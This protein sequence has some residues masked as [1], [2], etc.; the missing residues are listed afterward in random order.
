LGYPGYGYYALAT[1]AAA[2]GLADGC[3]LPERPGWSYLRVVY[4]VTALIGVSHSC[5]FEAVCILYFVYFVPRLVT[6]RFF[7]VV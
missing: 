7:Y 2:V 6:A 1:A 3:S 5:C 4:R